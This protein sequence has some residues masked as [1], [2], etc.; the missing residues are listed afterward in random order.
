MTISG[1]F[2]NRLKH[3]NKPVEIRNLSFSYGPKEVFRGLSL[4]SDSKFIVLKGPSGCGKTTLLK[5]ISGNLQPDSFDKM[6]EY[7]KTCM[8]IQEDA[9]LPWISGLKNIVKICK[10]TREEVTEHPMF[11]HVEPFIN[12]KA[13]NMSYGQRRLIELLRA[14]LSKP[15]LL[16]L[17]EPFN[18]L[19]PVSRQKVTS[20]LSPTGS[21]LHGTTV[22]MSTH[23]NEDMSEFAPDTFFFDGLLPVR[24]LSERY[25]F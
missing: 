16:C 21:H 25:E 24:S 9:L 1:S 6:P 3:W 22:L 2:V 15:D 11:K 18:F 5:L 12:Q 8:I 4:S 10:V 17:D 13:C 14:L 7:E 23:Y 19:D 20:L